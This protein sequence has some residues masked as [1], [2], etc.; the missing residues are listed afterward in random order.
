MFPTGLEGV[1]WVQTEAGPF[2]T[3]LGPLA[4]NLTTHIR[5]NPPLASHESGAVLERRKAMTVKLRSSDSVTI[6]HDHVYP[7]RGSSH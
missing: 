6:S 1:N 5:Q 2:P 4:E 7:K 3:G